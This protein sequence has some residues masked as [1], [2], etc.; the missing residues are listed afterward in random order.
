MM[1]KWLLTQCNSRLLSESPA[2][3]TI[4]ATW[5][6]QT[7]LS[8]CPQYPSASR[9]PP[10]SEISTWVT[11]WPSPG[12]LSIDATLYSPDP[13]LMVND[14]SGSGLRRLLPKPPASQYDFHSLALVAPSLQNFQNFEISGATDNAD[15][16]SDSPGYFD[17][18]QS[19]DF[20][21]PT[22]AAR[23]CISLK[24]QGYQS[25]GNKE[26][27]PLSPKSAINRV[28]KRGTGRARGPKTAI[29]CENCR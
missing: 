8:I 17:L 26:P 13:G 20:D 25:G 11:P 4:S 6:P 18:A 9:E 2:T 10:H 16:S 24:S 3:E 21:R 19:A 1:I 12:W 22:S 23:S 14:S 29:A 28:R 7:R 27:N 5:A 15:F